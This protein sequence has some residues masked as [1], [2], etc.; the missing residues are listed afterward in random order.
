[1]DSDSTENQVSNDGV[2]EIL[3]PAEGPRENL[4][5]TAVKFLQNPKVMS[6]PLYQKKAFLEK[7][8]LTQV[9]IDLAVQRA[10]VVETASAAQ[11]NQQPQ[12][13]GPPQ[14]Y[15]PGVVPPYY[16]IP[17]QSGWA[18][19][20]DL[21]MTTVVVASVSYAVYQLF[22][23]YLR[24]WL[25]GKSEQER[26]LERIEQEVKVI[27][28]MH[29][30]LAQIASTLTSVQAALSEQQE[31]KYLR[32]WLLGKSE[33]ERRLERIEQ[34]IKVI[35]SMHASLA[36]IASTLTSV[37]AALSEQQEQHVTTRGELQGISDL[38]SD[39]A[40]LK[41]LML[42]KNQFPALPTTTPVLPSWQRAP[43]SSATPSAPPSSSSSSSSKEPPASTLA[44]PGN[45]LAQNE[46]SSEES[47]GLGNDEQPE[48]LGEEKREAKSGLLEAGEESSQEQ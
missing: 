33:Q 29:A 36:Q 37:H 31:Q 9:E 25:L 15:Q 43:A 48:D 8:G 1:M 42:N 6:S 18:R 17:P 22:Q 28:S 38:K 7:K 10:G 32:P 2:K 40:S 45:S 46:T 5:N 34:E 4:I 23:K 30:S 44:S 26:R 47:N 14:V 11:P 41:G 39:I 27:Q 3:A 21:T 24:P 12:Q 16:P 19:A 35:Q 13:M 20:R